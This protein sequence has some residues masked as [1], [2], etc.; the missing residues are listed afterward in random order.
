M[1]CDYANSQA[2]ASLLPNGYPQL[3]GTASSFGFGDRT[4]LATPGHIQAVRDS[5]SR[6]APIL[7]QQSIREMTR[8]GRTP[9]DVLSDAFWGAFRAG[10]Q[11]AWS[12]DADHLKDAEDI[13]AT[14]ESG[15]VFFTLDPSDH[16]DP[17][18]DDCTES[19]LRTR[20]QAMLDDRVSQADALLPLYRGKSYDLDGAGIK[21]AFTE[22]GLLRAVVKYGRAL[23]HIDQMNRYL[24]SQLVGRRGFELEISVDESE[25][26]TSLL[27]HLFITLEL[28]RLG[29]KFVSLAPRF[30]GDFEKGIDYRG[31]LA[32]LEKS[33]SGHAAIAKQY[34]PYKLSLHSGSDK[35]SIYPLFARHAGGMLH[36]KTSGT[37]YLE[38]LRVV[39]RVEPRL[40]RQ[41]AEF[42]REHFEKDCA[43]Y[44]ISTR[45]DMVPEPSQVSNTGEL[46][47]LY[48]DQAPGRQVL[49]VTFGSVLSA[50]EDGGGFLSGTGSGTCCSKTGGCMM[51]WWPGTW[52]GISGCCER[53]PV[54]P[55]VCQAYIEYADPRA[56]HGRI[57]ALPLCAPPFVAAGFH[58]SAKCYMLAV[59]GEPGPW[60]V[61]PRR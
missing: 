18:A 10:W 33:L 31:D 40:F 26:P 32:I 21:I 25:Q 2:L 4:G 16:V 46:E 55:R 22:E 35:F 7:A 28:K 52:A 42:S 43:T 15:F 50:R 23:A 5:D 61:T 58:R 49:H 1:A 41:I 19:E 14:V 51:N 27:E 3:L 53:Q 17:T 20:Y 6:M 29:V 39:L 37:S 24:K 59:A 54:E 56:R 30:D 8:T 13:Q 11:G 60:G 9:K 34:G 47:R 44:H 36:V 38:A 57:P 12:A 45:L 48:L